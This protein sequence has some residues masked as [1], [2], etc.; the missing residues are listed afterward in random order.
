MSK[1]LGNLKQGLLFVISAPAGTGKTTLVNMLCHEFDCIKASKSC[2]TRQPRQGEKPGVHYDFLLNEE[3][4]SKIAQGEFL[5]YVQLY[6][7]YYGT[8]KQ[9]VQRQLQ[10]GKHVILTIDT[11]GA[12]KL[13]GAVSAIFIFLQ[14]PSL[15]ELRKRL[16]H[17]QT[18]TDEVIEKRL[19]WAEKEM[20]AAVLYDYIIINDDLKIAYEILRS[21]FIAEEHRTKI[22]TRETYARTFN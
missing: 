11:Q 1:L 13:K 19:S 16:T 8:L 14:P 5:E 18:E 7:H 15:E 3:F 2:T 9:T 4:E 22:N 21:I 6:G 20:A 17:R 12:L 10:A